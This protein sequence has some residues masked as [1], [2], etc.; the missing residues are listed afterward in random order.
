MNIKKTFIAIALLG[1]FPLQSFADGGKV[2]YVAPDGNDTAS[3]SIEEPLATLPA[4]YKK[5]AGGDTIYFRGGTYKVTDEQVMKIESLYAH[6]FALELKKRTCASLK[7]L[8][9]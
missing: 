9:K 4:A 7:E 8:L 2:I 5:I 1:I 3:G 6:T